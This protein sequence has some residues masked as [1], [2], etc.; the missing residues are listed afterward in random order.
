VEDH[1]HQHRRRAQQIQVPVLPVLRHGR[2]LWPWWIN[3][4]NSFAPRPG[5]RS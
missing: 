4:P 1:D 2:I 5:L 3:R